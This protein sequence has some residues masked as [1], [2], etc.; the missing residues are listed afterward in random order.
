MTKQLY[1]YDKLFSN[2]LIKLAA[3][4]ISSHSTFGDNFTTLNEEEYS[5]RE[6][7]LQILRQIENYEKIMEH[8]LIISVIQQTEKINNLEFRLEKLEDLLEE[9]HNAKRWRET[10]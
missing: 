2:G 7:C 5:I 3:A 1:Y 9:K 10:K 4:Y 8:P 6:I